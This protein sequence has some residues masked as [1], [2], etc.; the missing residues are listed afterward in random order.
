MLV[1]L[2]GSPTLAECQKKQRDL[3]TREELLTLEKEDLNLFD[4]IRRLKPHFLE[5]PKG[6]RTLG[7]GAQYPIVVVVDGR[8]GD[9]QMLEQLRALD[10]REVR[11]L[12]PARAQSEYGITAN[13]GAI[14]IKRVNATEKRPE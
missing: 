12:E 7:G 6:R 1:S 13:S 5:A 10:V 4:A 9:T 2:A 8:R 3:L 14:V 11:Y